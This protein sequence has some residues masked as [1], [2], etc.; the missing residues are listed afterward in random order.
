M[1]RRQPVSLY[2]LDPQQLQ[3]LTMLLSGKTVTET[4]AAL[5]VARETVSRWK[6]KD[7]A[8]QSAFADARIAAYEA[9]QTRLRDVR[10]KA[11]D[12]LE[13]LLDAT[14]DDI[15]LKAAVAVVKLPLDRPKGETDPERVSMFQW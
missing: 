3:A 6:H 11:F 9:E 15:A 1:P 2:D 14:N 12:K 4:A 10:Q 7:P 8:F 13:D 5:D